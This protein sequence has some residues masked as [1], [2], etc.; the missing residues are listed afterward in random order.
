M[1]TKPA[2]L[3]SFA[4]LDTLISTQS[5]LI[6]STLAN[7]LDISLPSSRDARTTPV[8]SKCRIKAINPDVHHHVNN[9]LVTFDGSGTLDRNS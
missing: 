5:Y 7:E 8:L 2:L 9:S 6:S 4:D 1:V 3:P